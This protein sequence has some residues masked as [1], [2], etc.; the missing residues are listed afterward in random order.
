MHI[1]DGILS[2]PVLGAGIGITAAGVGI[3]LKKLE[4]EKIPEAAIFA[5]AFL[6]INLIHFPIGMTSAHL[7][8][9][10]LIGLLFG[11]SAFP[12]IFIGLLLQTLFF[13]HGGLIVLGV[14]TMNMALPAVIVYYMFSFLLK[15]D[16]SE[17]KVFLIGFGAGFISFFLSIIMTGSSLY[18]SAPQKFQ[19]TSLIFLTS[20][21]PLLFLEGGITGI[22]LVYLKKMKPEIFNEKI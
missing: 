9:N 7:V 3:G 21:L 22:I 5:S 11:L 6:V 10:G 13:G 2:L 8:L 17:K 1:A 14:N 20:N 15:K 4:Y 16:I 18:F 12:V 19:L